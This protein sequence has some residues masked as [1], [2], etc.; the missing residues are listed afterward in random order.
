MRHYGTLAPN[1]Q[2]DVV[3][4]TMP[5]VAMAKAKLIERLIFFLKPLT[6]SLKMAMGVF[7]RSVG[8]I[9]HRHWR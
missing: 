2:I 5:Y 6:Q 3:R 7:V 9:A 4:V 1:A 8:L